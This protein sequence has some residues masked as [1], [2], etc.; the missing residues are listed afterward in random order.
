MSTTMLAGK[1]YTA[2]HCRKGT[3]TIHVTSTTGEW[4]SG[5]FIDGEY[6]V[7]NQLNAREHGDEITVRRT[8]LSN[9]KE[10]EQ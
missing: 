6:R 9:V 4:V 2:N 8:F 3:M 1:T 5:T 7:L 10:V